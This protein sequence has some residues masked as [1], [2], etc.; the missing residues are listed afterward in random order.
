MKI[1]QPEDNNINNINNI[2]QNKEIGLNTHNFKESIIALEPKGNPQ[3]N[4]SATVTT[5][6]G[7]LKPEPD[8]KNDT[9]FNLNNSLENNTISNNSLRKDENS[10]STADES[11][12]QK[13][14]RWAGALWSKINVKNYFPK[15][16]YLEYRNAN[17]DMVK[18]PK[19]KLPLKK[20]K[21]EV[22]DEQYI[23]N[24][25][26]ERDRA[27]MNFYAADNV[28]YASAFI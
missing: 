22:D 10:V 17:G 3:E 18:V 7:F 23:V 27:K 9:L 4:E 28:P 15:T 24:K 12:Y 14:K 13:T 16:E 6:I 19:K 25:T 1:P 5:V 20:K 2:N 11:F 21:V 8:K 26:V